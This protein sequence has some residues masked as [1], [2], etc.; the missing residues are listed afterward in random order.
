MKV[1][2]IG[3]S[4]LGDDSIALRLQDWLQRKGFDVEMCENSG[5]DIIDK[6][7]ANM[8][9]IDAVKSEQVGE[10]FIIPTE[11]LTDRQE[12]SLHDMGVEPALKLLFS[13]KGIK[14]IILGI[15]IKEASLSEKICPELDAK[16]PE[17]RE[18]VVEILENA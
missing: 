8:A 16:L 5:F 4:L 11:K 2:L 18:K 13:M 10:V 6:A 7:E 17:I 3:N 12:L 14:P 15:G 9:I 1:F